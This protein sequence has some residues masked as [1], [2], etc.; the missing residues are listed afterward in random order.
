MFGMLALVAAENNSHT[1]E[2][3]KRRILR[4]CSNPLDLNESTVNKDAF[5]MLVKVVTPHVKLSSI[6]S[7]IQLA[8]TLRFLAEGGF[9]KAVGIDKQIALGRSTVGKILTNV[10]AILERRICPSWIKLE[11]SDAERS[12]SKRH[13]MQKF[14]IPGVVGCV[15]GTHIRMTKP[16]RDHHLFYNRKGYFSINAMIICDYKMTI[17]AVNARRAGSS[18]DSLIWCVSKAHDYFCQCYESGERGSWLLGD[19]GYSLQPFLLTPYRDP[20]PGTQEHKFNVKHA[21]ARNV[22]ERAIGVL[23]SRF[24]CLARLLQYQPEK[25]SKIIN[26]CCALHNICRYYKVQD[27]EDVHFANKDEEELSEISASREANT[28]R[29]DIA[30]SLR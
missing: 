21:S 3:I 1:N 12:A 18:H 6:P 25:V 9:Q 14:G 16:H 27:V 29:D 15:D 20:Q 13:F 30:N 24:R 17:R 22:I 7:S 19:A 23:K 2:K 10:I 5:C 4:D 11:M 28:I 8:C 26:V